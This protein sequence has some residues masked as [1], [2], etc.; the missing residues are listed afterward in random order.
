MSSAFI[1][2]ILKEMQE[3]EGQRDWREGGQLFPTD[4]C[5]DI[6]QGHDEANRR[7]WGLPTGSLLPR[8]FGF[9]RAMRSKAV[10]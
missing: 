1:A 10:N 8:V 5:G 3:K 4:P 2:V 9:L 7:G 6:M